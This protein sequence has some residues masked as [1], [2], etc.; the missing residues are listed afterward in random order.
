EIDRKGTEIHKKIENIEEE[1]QEGLSEKEV[2]ELDI[3]VGDTV[4]LKSSGSRGEVVEIDDDKNEA[5]LRAGVMT[6]RVKMEELLRAEMPDMNKEKMLKKYQVSKA[7]RV[8][9]RLDLR[10]ER[11]ENARERV[12]KYLDDVFLAGLKEVEVIHGK[13]TGALRKAV[14]TLL[15]DHPHVSSFRAGRQEEGGSGVTIVKLQ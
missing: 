5:V 13:G 6:V 14:R 11:Y 10:G 12:D 8:S 1:Y 15:E 9:S 4:R 3:S 2:T 7:E